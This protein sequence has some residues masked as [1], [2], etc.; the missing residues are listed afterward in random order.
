MNTALYQFDSIEKRERTHWRLATIC[1]L[2][3]YPAL[4]FFVATL[5]SD[6]SLGDPSRQ[7]LVI[8]SIGLMVRLVLIGILFRSAYKKHKTT[9]LTIALILV[10]VNYVTSI[11]RLLSRSDDPWILVDILISLGMY[12]WWCMV[13]LK[14]LRLNK[15]IKS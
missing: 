5:S 7:P 14:L 2:G 8:G 1:Y 3:I 4:T 11:P 13:S 9:L 10:F 12:A 6:S 15:R